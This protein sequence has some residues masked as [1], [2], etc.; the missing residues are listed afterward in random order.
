M[1]TKHTL[2][3]IGL[4]VAGI[5]GVAG[6]ASASGRPAGDLSTA[7]A[8]C[9]AA[10]D[11]RLAEIDK[12]S[13]KAGGVKL[14]TAGHKSTIDGFLSSSRSGLADL[15]VKVD[16]D[17][18]A[19][20]LKTDCESVATGYRIFALRSPQVHLAIVGDRQSFA[21]TKGNKVADALQAA[22]D[23]AEQLGKDVTAAQA[24]LDDMR[25]KLADASTQL[26]GTVDSELGLTPADWNADH[27]VL[28]GA[29][30][31]LRAAQA[32][33]KAAFADAKAIVSDLKG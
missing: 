29:T 14:L 9:E 24:S 31:K 11:V 22:I 30:T 4:A 17:T 6:T 2:A 8:K 21:V 23:K 27:T 3:A 16:G 28:N 12:L 20:T 33:L 13:S 15:R 32:D 19:A 1:N 7:K 10:I 25:A 26:G 18:D 5:V